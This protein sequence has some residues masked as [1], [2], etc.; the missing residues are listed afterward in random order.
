M[1]PSK[2]HA[3]AM[4]TPNNRAQQTTRAQGTGQNVCWA[5]QERARITPHRSSPRTEDWSKS[6]RKDSWLAS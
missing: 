3:E 5:E 2:E 6:S 1:G 4:E